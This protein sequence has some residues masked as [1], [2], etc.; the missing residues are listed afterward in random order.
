MKK[1]PT[2]L[3]VTIE[4]PGTDDAYLNAQADKNDLVEMHQTKTVG[5]YTLQ[6]KVKIKG[7]AE[8]V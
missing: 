6:R 7:V 3:F 1:L 2:I 8:E 4:E 5:E